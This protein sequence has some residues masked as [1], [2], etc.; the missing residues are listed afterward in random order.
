MTTATLCPVCRDP[1]AQCEITEELANRTAFECSVCGSFVVAGSALK[2]KLHTGTE[3]WLNKLQHALLSH[4][5]REINDGG[6]EPPL[7]TT[8]D[9]DQVISSGRL[10]SPAQQAVNIIRF[11]GDR[12][13]ESGN[14]VRE[15]PPHFHA[16]VGSPNR[17]FALRICQQLAARGLVSAMDTATFDSPYDV[18]QVDLTLDGWERY[19][20]ERRG[21]VSTRRGFIALQFGDEVLD[22]FLAEVIKPAVSSIGYELED[23]RDAAR[24]GVIDNVMRAKIRDAAF[25]LVDLTHGNEGAYWEAGYAEGLGKPVLYLCQRR[26]FEARG[27]HFDTNHCTTVQWEASDPAGFHADLIATLRRSLGLFGGNA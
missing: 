12:I 7:L 15:L 10:P 19:E 22:R 23:M 24:A 16:S 8:Y 4:R 17:D 26:E 3:V 27:T 11:L 2:G 14:P 20:S 18:M 9:V 13:S 6:G 1:E 21:E 5:V 25:V